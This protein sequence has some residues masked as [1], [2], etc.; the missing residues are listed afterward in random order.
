MPLMT[1]IRNNMSKAFAVFAACFIVY[2]VLDWGMDITNR[3]HQQGS[4]DYIGIVNGTK[5]NYS[6]FSALLKQ[7]SD[8]YRKQSNAEADDETERQLRTQV[9]NT[10]V[11]QTLIEHELERLNISVTDDEVRE[12]ILGPNPPQMIANQFIDSTGKFDRAKYDQAMQNP[13]N[14][15]ILV[16]IEGEVRRQRRLEKLQSLLFA[17]TRV[18]DPEIRQRFEDKSVAMEAEYALFDPNTLIPDSMVLVS[19]DDLRKHYNANQEEFKVRPARKMKYVLFSTAPTGEDSA[20]VLTEMNRTIDQVKAG[21]DFVELAKTYS[22][23]PVNDTA[24][25]KHGDLSRQL[26]AA[27]F[28]AKKGEIV[29]PIGD[30]AGFH[31]T[32]V[33]A[34]RKGSGEFVRASHILLNLVSGPDSVA[35]IQKAKDILR[36][37]RSGENFGKLVAEFSED[38][39]SKATDGD[40]GWTGKGGWVK[41]FEQA[42]FGAK[43]GDIVGPIRSQ[44]GWHIIKVLGKDSRELRVATLT[45]KVKMGSRSSDAASQKAQDF[46]YLAKEEGYEKAAETSTYA[47]R[48]TPEFVKGSVIPGIGVNDAAMN[49][50][51]SKKVDALSEPIAVTGGLAVFKITAVREEGVRPLDEVKS[52]LRSQVLREKKL[53]KLK[54]Q[55]DSFYKTL[56]PTTDFSTAGR[57]MPGVVVQRTG[58]FKAVDAPQGVGR[59]YAFIGQAVSLKPGELSKPFEGT[60]GYYILKMLSKTAFDSTQFSGEKN[61]LKDQILQEKRNR[62]FSDW[63]TALRDKA[64]IDDQRDKFFR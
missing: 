26:E 14:R 45:M 35:K 11:Q 40:L 5:I 46:A 57:T 49:F 43:V 53:Q 36:R 54:D 18:S 16:Q 29:G 42:A 2:I 39:G 13:Q 62:M 19:D 33:L 59:D 6:E 38:H 56:G 15:Q 60:R 28:S 64:T 50:A 41:P 3:K 37:A 34:E 1:K 30:Y 12:L 7:Q 61:T 47:V 4:R 51:Y 21:S 58:S 10:M 25:V 32:K 48:E 55:V 8:A 31:I 24:F 22:E 17:S 20:T 9:W 52:I 63:I 44:F 27:V 23:R